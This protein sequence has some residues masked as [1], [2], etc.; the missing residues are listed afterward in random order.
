MRNQ[1]FN[2]GVIRPIECVREGWELIKS[3]YWLLFAISLVGGLIAGFTFYVLLGAMICGIFGCYLKKIDGKPVVFEELW[4]GFSYLGPSA[5]VTIAFVVPMVVYFVIIFVTIYSPLIA[6]AAMGERADPS[7]VLGV[8]A[9]A[10][11]VDLVVAIAM[12]CIHSLIM[13]AFPLIVDRGMSGW[14]AINLSARAS[15]K[16]IGGIAGLVVVNFLLSLLGVFTC[17]G[18]YFV[19][20]IM[21]AANLV[22]YRKVFPRTDAFRP[23]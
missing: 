13:F 10:I 3:E 9:G 5:L 19:I 22:A 16:N 8:F 17:F 12:T 23:F 2:V 15:M 14:E 18:M 20:P 4:R 7:I 11:G 21:T 1:E 6:V